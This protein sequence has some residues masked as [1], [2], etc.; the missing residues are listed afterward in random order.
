MDYKNDLT[1][2]RLTMQAVNA[3]G[4]L[5]DEDAQIQFD[6]WYNQYVAP[7]F[8]GAVVVHGDDNDG[9][10]F[11]MF[12]SHTMKM[13]AKCHTHMGLLLGV[14]KLPRGV[15]KEELNAAI[16]GKISLHS[17]DALLRRIRDEGLKNG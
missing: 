5:L 13:P 1:P 6:G 2:P 10:G 3:D 7:L 8:Y 16:D 4:S 12:H 11:A 14:Q 9:D 17:I 15:T